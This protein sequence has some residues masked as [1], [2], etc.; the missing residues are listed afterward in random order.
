MADVA[1][2]SQD[3]VFAVFPNAAL[4]G[5]AAEV[6]D[7]AI[8]SEAAIMDTH[9]RDV[10]PGLRD[11]DP[12]WESFAAWGEDVRSC[13]YV[14]AAT[15]LMRRRGYNPASGADQ[16]IEMMRLEK[17][18]WLKDVAAG[19]VVAN[20]TPRQHDVPAYNAPQIITGGQRG[21]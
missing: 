3:D 6:I 7:L 12:G 1:Y 20:I 8:K 4:S 10:S 13:N 11:G 15:Q 21:W 5:L 14:L 2:C 19:R 16:T 18:A 17:M 9:F